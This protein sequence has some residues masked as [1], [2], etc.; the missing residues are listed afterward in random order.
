MKTANWVR[1][2]PGRIIG[3]IR[4]DNDAILGGH[5]LGRN[6]QRKCESCCASTGDEGTTVELAWK[7]IHRNLTNLTPPPAPR[8][9]IKL[10]SNRLSTA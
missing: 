6:I 10:R 5:R 3:S 4:A 8:V 9:A 2:A 1:K 7:T